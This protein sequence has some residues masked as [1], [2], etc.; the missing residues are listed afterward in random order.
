VKDIAE[1]LVNEKLAACI[2]IIPE[3]QSVFRWKDKVDNAPEN[4]LIIKTTLN[5]YD[6]LER[7]IKEL[8]P[9]ELPEIIAVPIEKGLTEY[10]NWVS[11]NTK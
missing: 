6:I 2:N 7:R 9:Y 3:V 4:I 8:H 10:L 11:E 1:K 5:L